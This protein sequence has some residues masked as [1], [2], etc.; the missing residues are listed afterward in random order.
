[1]V[2]VGFSLHR[3]FELPQEAGLKPFDILLASTVNPARYLHTYSM[4]GIISEGKYADLVV[5]NKNPLAD[6]NNTKAIEGVFLK[7]KWFN[8]G[9][10]DMM[11]KEV[12]AAYR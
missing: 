12:E 2:I 10:L 7:G 4:N 6:I 5:L 11:L 8:R 9:M 1:M 3:E